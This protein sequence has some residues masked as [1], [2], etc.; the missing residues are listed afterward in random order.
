MHRVA[1]P[2]RITVAHKGLVF[3]I[4]TDGLLHGVEVM[5]FEPGDILGPQQ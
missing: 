5:P 2:H 4:R 1:V 3:D